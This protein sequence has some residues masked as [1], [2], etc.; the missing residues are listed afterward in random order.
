MNKRLKSISFHDC[1]HDFLAGQGTGTATIKVKLAQQLAYIEQV[2]LY[3]IFI[4]LSKAYDLMDRGR[5]LLILEA[6]GVS[7]NLLRVFKY[8]WEHAELVCRAE[9]VFGD[10]FKAE[11]GAVQGGPVSP[12]IFNVMV[13]AIVR[14]WIRQTL[15][16]NAMTTKI[17][18][19][20][21]SFLAAFYA[22]DRILQ[23]RDPVRL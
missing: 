21:R 6:Y 19:E 22:D 16:D 5:V 9:G 11:R 14:K 8:F 13:D 20:I 15:G 4:D 1:L 12:T 23:S 18:E 10:P 7:P 17:G 2:P 3:G